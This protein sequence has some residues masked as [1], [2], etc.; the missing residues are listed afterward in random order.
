MQQAGVLTQQDNEQAV[1]LTMQLWLNEAPRH[2]VTVQRMAHTFRPVRLPGMQP[3]M[4]PA[5]VV[6]T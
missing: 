2:G 5:V 6:H 3:G 1:E 4:V